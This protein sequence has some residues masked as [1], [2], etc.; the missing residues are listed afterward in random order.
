MVQEAKR[1]KQEAQ[2][3]ASINILNLDINLF[4]FRGHILEHRL[5]I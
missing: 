5:I 2:S 4:L 1:R 3:N